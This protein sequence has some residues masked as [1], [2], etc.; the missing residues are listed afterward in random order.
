MDK[1]CTICGNSRCD[2]YGVDRDDAEFHRG[3]RE[4]ERVSE[5]RKLYGDRVADQILLE[6]ER[7]YSQ[8]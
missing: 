4:M 3:Y 7:G 6:M 1:L 5:A 8:Y 2:G